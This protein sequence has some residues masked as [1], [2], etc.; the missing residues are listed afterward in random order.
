MR[1]IGFVAVK[2]EED[3]CIN[4]EEGRKQIIYV[5]CLMPVVHKT[6]V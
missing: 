5:F 4:A 6:S 1:R 2:D 3:G